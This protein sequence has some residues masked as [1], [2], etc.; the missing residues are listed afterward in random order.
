MGGRKSKLSKELF[1]KMRIQAKPGEEI[2]VKHVQLVINESTNKNAGLGLFAY[3]FI[4]KG[5]AFLEVTDQNDQRGYMINDLAYHG[6]LDNYETDE[7]IEKYINVGYIRQSD[8]AYDF[9]GTG[10]MK[11]YCYTLRDIQPGEE[12]SRIYGPLYWEEYEFW[13]KYPEY[14]FR[15]TR[16]L[17]QLPPEFVFIDTARYNYDLNN[18]KSFFGKKVGNEYY[19]ITGYG[20]DYFT[21]GFFDDMSKFENITKPDFSLYRWD[22]EIPGAG[23]SDIY[24]N[25]YLKQQKEQ[26]S[27]C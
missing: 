17:S 24:W 27:N 2:Q 9:L 7:N 19:F 21:P 22:E 10:E 3:E 14:K 5:T 8:V 4:P 18:N 23:M 25:H 26:T 6:T 20:R 15:E 13:A 1:Q 16:L 12:L 11:A